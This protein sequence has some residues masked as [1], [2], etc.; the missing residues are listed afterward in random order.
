M[1]HLDWT[2]RRVR[3]NTWKRVV[4]GQRS[5]DRAGRHHERFDTEAADKFAA[6]YAVAVG[7]DVSLIPGHS[8]GPVWLLDNEEI[9]VSIGRQSRRPHGHDFNWTAWFDGDRAGGSGHAVRDCVQRWRTHHR[10]R[11]RVGSSSSC[12]RR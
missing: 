2:G 8:E 3:R 12:V 9:K 11:E 1:V 4:E 10:E 6:A 5:R 7:L